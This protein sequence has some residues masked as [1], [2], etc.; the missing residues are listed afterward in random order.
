MISSP[1]KLSCEYIYLKVVNFIYNIFINYDLLYIKILMFIIYICIYTFTH[2]YDSLSWL[3]TN[4]LI[5]KFD[6]SPNKKHPNSAVEQGQAHMDLHPMSYAFLLY[7]GL[8]RFSIYNAFEQVVNFLVKEKNHL[9][10]DPI[11]GSV[12]ILA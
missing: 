1:K 6:P 9:T 7:V 11:C 3:E 10:W 2:V 4:I 8:K 12:F 5:S